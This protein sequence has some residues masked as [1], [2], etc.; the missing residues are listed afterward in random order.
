MHYNSPKSSLLF[1]NVQLLFIIIHC[2]IG[3]I[4]CKDVDRIPLA[5]DRVVVGCFQ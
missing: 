3:M 2:I 4:G 5:Q 1:F